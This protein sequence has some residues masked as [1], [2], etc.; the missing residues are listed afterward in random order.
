MAKNQFNDVSGAVTYLSR[1]NN[2]E[3][4]DIAT[5]AP[6]TMSMT[7]KQK[8]NFINTSNYNP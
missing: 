7:D 5:A 1:A 2:F 3:N 8:E 6:A 4:Y